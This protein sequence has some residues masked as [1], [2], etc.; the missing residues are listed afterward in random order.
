MTAR[1]FTPV[2]I[3]SLAVPNRIYVPPM[4]Q[5][6]ARDGL[7]TAWHRM[8]Y[9][10]LVAS[11]AGLVVME[12]T[13]VA[14]NGRITTRCLGLYNDEQERA[15]ARLV[16]ECKAIAPETRLMIQL[17]H[18]GRKGSRGDPALGRCTLTPEQGG[19]DLVAPSALRFDAN[20]PE[21]TAL[22]QE[23]IAEL[24]QAFAQAAVRAARAGF[25]GIQLHA[26]HGYLLHEF[27]SPLTNQ[28]QDAYGG[29]FARR[30]RFVLEVLEAVRRAAPNLALMMRVSAGDFVRDGDWTM[31]EAIAL[32]Q[33]AQNRGLDAADAS[34]GGLDPAQQ[35]PVLSVPFQAENAKRIKTQTQLVAY[36]VGNITDP[37]QAEAILDAQQ[38]DGIGIGRE[39]IRN[40]NWG[41]GAAQA[42]HAV[43]QMP[44]PYWS[45][46]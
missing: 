16:Q 6:Q 1:L 30:T 44:S 24:V 3:G 4:C 19:F 45:V 37:L 34:V 13:A 10:K 14:A 5:C 32:L 39:M 38:A 8:H 15:L 46:F 42:L 7:P 36:A 18:A 9:G 2:H 33:L 28:R 26:A 22:T 25:D 20:A 29:D 27:L 43:V 31:S 40:P 35:L 12:A 17:S 21:P 23:G 41:W 11:G